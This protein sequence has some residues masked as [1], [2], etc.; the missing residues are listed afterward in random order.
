ML[1]KKTE[2]SLDPLKGLLNIHSSI[3]SLEAADLSS[4]PFNLV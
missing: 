1:D 4:F 3:A 2:E